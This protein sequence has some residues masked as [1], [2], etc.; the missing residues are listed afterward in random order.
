MNGC[1]ILYCIQ[2]LKIV[3][4]EDGGNYLNVNPGTMPGI[5]RARQLNLASSGKAQVYISQHLTYSAKLF[6]TTHKGRMF[7]M[8][9]HPVKRIIDNF[10][11]LQR[12]T[13]AGHDDYD[14]DLGTMSLAQ[15][16]LSDK[17][18]E[19]FMVRSLLDLNDS[20]ELTKTHIDQ[21]KDIL[22]RK[23]I[24]G[25][26]EWFDVSVHRFEKYVELSAHACMRV[27]I[28]ILSRN[29]TPLVLF[30]SDTSDGGSHKMSGTTV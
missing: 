4:G 20:F 13:W 30:S 12:S 23:F 26:I 25:I 9:R 27:T 8:M 10:Y 7:V 22:R 19:N 21:A 14:L 24:V 16:A 11:F 17:M 2:S 5:D 15:Y 3:K 29:S 18:V 1:I 28:P 6:S